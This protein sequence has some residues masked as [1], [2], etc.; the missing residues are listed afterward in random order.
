MK[1]VEGSTLAEC[2]WRSIKPAPFVLQAAKG[3]DYAHD[4]D[5]VH[6]T[7]SRTT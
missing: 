6:P 7:S 3:V 5:V 4:H 2:P 1:F